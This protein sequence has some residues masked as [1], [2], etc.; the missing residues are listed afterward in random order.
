MS[1]NVQ[2][3]CKQTGRQYCG[4]KNISYGTEQLLKWRSE[5]IEKTGKNSMQNSFVRPG[6]LTICIKRLKS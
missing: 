5:S 3:C 1:T 6:N 2:D 4:D